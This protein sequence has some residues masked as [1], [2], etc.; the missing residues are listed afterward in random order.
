MV[1]RDPVERAHSNW[2]HLWSAGLEPVGDFVRACAEEERRIAA[3]WASFWHY[4]G[5]GRYGEQ[6]EYLFTLFPR[7]QVLVLR[8]R[9]LVDEPAQTLDRICGF[10][11]VAQGVLTEIPRQNVTSH[12][13]PT[14]GHRAVSAAQRAASAFGTLIP[15]LTA[16]TL[17]GPLERFLQRHS[18]E[19]QPL[20]WE[21]RQAAHPEVRVRHRAAR[22]GPR[23]ELPGLDPAAGASG[24]MVGGRPAG[25]GQARNGRPD[26]R[27][28]RPAR[29]PS[30][31][32]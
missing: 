3:G 1:L 27:S 25:Q 23:R 6:L 32:P 11:G 30:A 17:T 24:G 14:L 15:G 13:E 5:L 2:T 20:S 26:P 7:E 19:R 29:A 22:A 10:L 31:V 4:I 8:Y 18:R 16:A 12:P 21:Q 28:R 9:R